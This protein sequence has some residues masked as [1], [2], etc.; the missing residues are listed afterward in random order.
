MSTAF[1]VLSKSP[2]LIR[3]SANDGY[4]DEVSSF[5]AFDD[6][7][8]NSRHLQLVTRIFLRLDDLVVGTGL[9][10]GLDTRAARKRLMKCPK[11]RR[12]ALTGT[13]HGFTCNFCKEHHDERD[14][15]IE[16]V[17]T[18]AT[19]AWYKNTWQ[20]A[21]NPLHKL[22]AEFYLATKDKQSSI[23]RVEQSKVEALIEALRCDSSG[24]NPSKFNFD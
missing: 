13:R 3:W 9:V 19:R 12:T 5:Y 21:Q 1:L 18:V 15:V 20:P 22:Q 7:V 8:K 24:V 17:E 16:E 14:M 23:R 11:C 10:T 2:E 4:S 6:S